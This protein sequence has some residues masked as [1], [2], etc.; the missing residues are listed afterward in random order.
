MN[1]IVQKVLNKNLPLSEDEEDIISNV[2]ENYQMEKEFD[3]IISIPYI[4]LNEEIIKVLEHFEI[5]YENK[6]PSSFIFLIFYSSQEENDPESIF[7]MESKQR[8]ISYMEKYNK[9]EMEIQDWITL[10]DIFCLPI[11]NDLNENNFLY[12]YLKNINNIVSDIKQKK[13]AGQKIHP[14]CQ[15]II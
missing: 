6:V 10:I 15:Q 9:G 13:D 12:D 5:P 11:L 8:C 14:L 7:D 1:R 2:L 3:K 4:A